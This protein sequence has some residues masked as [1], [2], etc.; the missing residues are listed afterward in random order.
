MTEE[1][2]NRNKIHFFGEKKWIMAYWFKTRRK[3]EF[4]EKYLMDQWNKLLGNDFTDCTDERLHNIITWIKETV[5][6]MT[7]DEIKKKRHDS[8]NKRQIPQYIKKLAEEKGCNVK[9][10]STRSHPLKVSGYAVY[11]NQNAKK[12]VYGEKF[13][14]TIKQVEEYLNTKEDK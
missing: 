3:T 9:K 6:T 10:C 2:R 7:K 11:A 5:R 13:N 14:L 1:Q 8:A 12:A 4:T